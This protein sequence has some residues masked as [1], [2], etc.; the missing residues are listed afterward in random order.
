MYFASLF[1]SWSPLASS[2]V[3]FHKRLPLRLEPLPSHATAAR[4]CSSGHTGS[5]IAKPETLSCAFPTH[6]CTADAGVPHV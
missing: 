5:A 2:A 3:L 4:V 1:R 6:S